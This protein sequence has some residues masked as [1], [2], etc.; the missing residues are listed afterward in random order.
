[1]NLTPKE[2]EFLVYLAE[3][4]WKRSRA[5]PP[6]E[7][8]QSLVDRGFLKLS[9]ERIGPLATPTGELMVDI[10]EAGKLCL[11]LQRQVDTLTATRPLEGIAP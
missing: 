8:I 2:T 11:A 10:T 1:M 5:N 6:S 3:N 7:R 9:P 4:G